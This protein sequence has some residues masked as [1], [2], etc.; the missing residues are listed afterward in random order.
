MPGLRFREASRRA[1]EAGKI[2][3]AQLTFGNG[4]IMLG[5]GH[6]GRAYP[7]RG[8]EGHVWNFGDY[9]PWQDE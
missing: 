6:G 9:D 5:S 3:H 8:H 2:A 4:M 1:G 7:C